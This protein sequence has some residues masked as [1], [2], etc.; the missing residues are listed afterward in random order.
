MLNLSLRR[1][2]AVLGML[3]FGASSVII[4]FC[5]FIVLYNFLHRGDSSWVIGEMVIVAGLEINCAIVAVNL[6]S[7][8]ALF[9][10]FGGW[11]STGGGGGGGDSDSDGRAGEEQHNNK[12]KTRTFEFELSAVRKE[13]RRKK[14]NM[15]GPVADIGISNLATT[16]IFAGTISEE[17][18]CSSVH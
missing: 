16:E 6:P 13:R 18:L 1:K 5:R 7:M 11:R 15:A 3:S 2:V 8:G 14:H 12:I 10:S 4:A 9:T 17:E